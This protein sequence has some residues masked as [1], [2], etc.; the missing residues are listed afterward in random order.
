VSVRRGLA[1]AVVACSIAVLALPARASGRDWITSIDGA[2][3]LTGRTFTMRTRMPWSE[4]PGGN[5]FVYRDTSQFD[6]SALWNH[7]LVM[8]DP[9]PWSVTP[10]WQQ[11]HPVVSMER[12]VE[13]ARAAGDRPIL[14]PARALVNVER[15][16]CGRA[17]GETVTEAFFRCGLASTPTDYYLL[18]SQKLECDPDR[19]SEFVEGA[20]EA[21]TGSLL[22][23]LTATPFDECATPDVIADA[24]RASARYADGWGM[25]VCRKMGHWHEQIARA[26]AALDLITTT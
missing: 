20:S 2:R 12:F 6:P 3:V 26:Q 16:V 19:F 23:E 21:V 25:W 14:A 8:Y 18:Q 24:W 9:E 5:V 10:M 11:R 22:V 15:A 7:A 4:A 1:V 13:K 17:R